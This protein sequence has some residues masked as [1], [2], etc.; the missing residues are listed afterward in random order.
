MTL[1]LGAMLLGV[2][3]VAGYDELAGAGDPNGAMI[4]AALGA[5]L[6]AALVYMGWVLDNV[7]DGPLE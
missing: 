4:L 3:T 6:A 2:V 1:V 5:A 7:S